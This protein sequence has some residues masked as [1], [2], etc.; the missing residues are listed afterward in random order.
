MGVGEPR[1]GSQERFWWPGRPDGDVVLEGLALNPA[2]PVDLLLALLRAHSG[3]AADGL[4]R[5]RELPPPVVGAMLHH[6]EPW[7][8]AALGVNPWVGAQVRLRLVDDPDGLVRSR[9]S[10]QRDL[11]VPDHVLGRGLDRLDRQVER[12]LMGLEELRG[13]LRE[14]L[15]RDR[16]L[17]PVAVRHPRARIRMVVSSWPDLL[18]GAARE[19]LLHDEAPQVR[20]AAVEHLA[21]HGRPRVPGDLPHGPGYERRGVLSAPLSRALVD[22][23]VAVGG[24]GDL[25]VVAANPTTPAD[26]VAALLHHRSAQVRRH[27]ATAT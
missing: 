2:I 10:A 20:A 1:A 13:E 12:G 14:E 4:R 7:V 17:V 22:E 25:S 26:V 24:D 15:L 23:V 16:R 8:R 6:R 21:R 3:P 18:D 11:P 5:R 19:A 9:V 27:L